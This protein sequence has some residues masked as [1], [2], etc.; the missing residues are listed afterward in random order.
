MGSAQ[1]PDLVSWTQARSEFNFD[2]DR[3]GIL[4]SSHHDAQ[5]TT[6]SCSAEET[7]YTWIAVSI[8]LLLTALS[9]CGLAQENW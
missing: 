8:P 3:L 7:G 6:G 1:A 4:T 5:M 2:T 9:F